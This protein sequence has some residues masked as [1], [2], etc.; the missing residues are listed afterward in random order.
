MVKK[1]KIMSESSQSI[2]HRIVLAIA[3]SGLA[4]TTIKQY[5]RNLAALVKMAG[6]T[7][8]WGA[9]SDYE[10]TISTLLLK[11]L[12]QPSSLQVFSG[13]V[14]SAFRYVPDLKSLASDAWA[15]WQTVSAE[16]KKPMNDRVLAAQPTMRQSLGWI[17]FQELVRKR[18]ALPVGSDGRMLLGIYSFIAARR[19]DY[20]ALR[21]FPSQPAKGTTTGNYIILAPHGDSTLVMQDYK[22]A[23]V[24]HTVTEVLPKVLV[25]EI[26]AYLARPAR[27]GSQDYLF[28]SQKTGKPYKSDATFS[29][30]ANTLLL[31]LF[32][33]PVTLTILRHVYISALDFNNLTIKERTEIALKMGHSIETQTRYKWML[34]D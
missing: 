6:K 29:A 3:S 9:I 14:L 34:R 20:W 19:N 11:F 10:H 5:N 31:S 16:A 26:R 23:K 24:Y 21:L 22:T 1:K 32:M 2:S 27:R 8:I 15:A 17:S 25:A 7:D 28:V 30:W 12:E 4:T 33:R 18:D 13:A